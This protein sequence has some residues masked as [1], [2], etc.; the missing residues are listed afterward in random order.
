RCENRELFTALRDA[1]L[2][3]AMPASCDILTVP[4]CHGHIL[5]KYI[6]LHA[7]L[8]RIFLRYRISK[9]VIQS[10]HPYSFFLEQEL[11]FFRFGKLR[12]RSTPKPPSNKMAL[13][14][15]I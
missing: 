2:S 13:D 1:A 4:D 6:I 10:L 5:H 3:I 9:K 12:A 8:S 7:C 11:P 15:A 14:F